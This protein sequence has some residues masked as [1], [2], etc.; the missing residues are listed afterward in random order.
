M[1]SVISRLSCAVPALAPLRQTSNS[2]VHPAPN[3]QRR[4][5]D[6]GGEGSS[7][8][9]F[10]GAQQETCVAE[11]WHAI[12][13]CGEA[14]ASWMPGQMMACATMTFCPLKVAAG[15]PYSR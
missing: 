14:I 4:L 15:E 12:Q 11:L 3:G 1:N 6:R 5:P 13:D 8:A 9:V 2:P 7:I 10:E